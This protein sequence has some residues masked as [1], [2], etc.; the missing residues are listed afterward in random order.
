MVDIEAPNLED[1]YIKS[2]HWN[3]QRIKIS[4]DQLKYPALSWCIDLISINLLSLTYECGDKSPTLVLMKALV[5]LQVVINL[6]P[7]NILDSCWYP[8]IMKF[9][10]KLKQLKA[11]KSKCFHGDV[12]I[13][14][15][16]MSKSSVPPLDDTTCT[17]HIKIGTLGTNSLVD[18]LDNLLWISPQLDNLAF[19]YI[20]RC[21]TCP[22]FFEKEMTH[23]EWA[24]DY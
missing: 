18:V 11:T 19:V 13:I 24:C 2:R 8:M 12:I 6:F 21:I 17:L 23:M 16:D 14:P 1:L 7:G 3:L 20:R 10:G 22:N 9:L 5:L 15:K 4:S